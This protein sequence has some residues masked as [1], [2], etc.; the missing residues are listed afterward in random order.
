M[1]TLNSTVTVCMCC[2]L[3]QSERICFSFKKIQHTRAMLLK[4]SAV[5]DKFLNYLSQTDIFG[6]DS[7]INYW[8][9]KDQ[10]FQY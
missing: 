2:L 9:N 6:K 10:V 1:Q 7:K 4:L 8:E 5:K 3:G